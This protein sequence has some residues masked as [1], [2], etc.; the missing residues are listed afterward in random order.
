[1]VLPK[2]GLIEAHEVKG[3]WMDDARVKIKVAAAQ[4]P[5]KFIAVKARTKKDG[6][7]WEVEEF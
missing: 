3:Y 7:G 4:H 6:G 5:V 1:M 2:T